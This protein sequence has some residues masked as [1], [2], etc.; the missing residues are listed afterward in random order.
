[1][2]AENEK[3]LCLQPMTHGDAR[4]AEGRE[5]GRREGLL[6]AIEQLDLMAEGQRQ[7]GNFARLIRTSQCYQDAA[8]RLRARLRSGLTA[9]APK[10]GE[11]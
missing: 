1:M 5:A 8:D 9:F 3:P 6:Y 7:H 2:S 4:Y 11:P 10:D